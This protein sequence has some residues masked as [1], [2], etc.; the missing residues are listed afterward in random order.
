[1]AD[2]AGGPV[3]CHNHVCLENVVFREGRAVALIDWDFAA[4][5]RPVYDLAQMARM[6]VPVDDGESAARVGFVA[7]DRPSDFGL[8]VTRYG[9]TRTKRADANRRTG[10]GDPPWRASS[11]CAALSREIPTSSACGRRSAA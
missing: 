8:C 3:I 2:P 1:M 10:R 11:C 5:G 9:L 6:C 4:P 7:A